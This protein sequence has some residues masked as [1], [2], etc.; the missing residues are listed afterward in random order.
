MF[1][2]TTFLATCCASALATACP[3]LAADTQ[4]FPSEQ[5]SI[6]AT[7]IVKGLDHP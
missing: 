5:G 7:P 6:T 4:Q 2:R 3:V 1:L